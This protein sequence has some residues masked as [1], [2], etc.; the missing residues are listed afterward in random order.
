MDVLLWPDDVRVAPEGQDAHDLG[1]LAAHHLEAGEVAV[2]RRREN[3]NLEWL[4]IMRVFRREDQ[5]TLWKRE[6][7]RSGRRNLGGNVCVDQIKLKVEVK[8]SHKVYVS[9]SPDSHSS[10][11]EISVSMKLGTHLT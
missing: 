6:P 2:V 8:P 7:Q 11:T 3:T 9:L 5:F 4:A 1:L 10:S